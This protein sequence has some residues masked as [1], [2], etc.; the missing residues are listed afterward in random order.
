CKWRDG[1]PA[2]TFSTTASNQ[3]TTAAFEPQ[4][5][6]PTLEAILNSDPLKPAPQTKKLGDLL[7]EKQESADGAGDIS[8]ARGGGRAG[9]CCIPQL[10]RVISHRERRN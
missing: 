8:G 3:A 7:K 10:P 5:K 6:L 4:T 1:T 2:R 9:R